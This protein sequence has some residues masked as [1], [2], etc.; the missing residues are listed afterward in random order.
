MQMACFY[1]TFEH[2]ES[3]D[4]WSEQGSPF[5]VSGEAQAVPGDHRHGEAWVAGS[6]YVL[7]F[8]PYTLPMISWRGSKLQRWHQETGWKAGPV[9]LLRTF[10]FTSQRKAGSALDYGDYANE[11]VA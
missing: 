5:L 6:S 2:L 4:P 8:Q 9:S 10:P 7:E 11:I 1:H 3:T